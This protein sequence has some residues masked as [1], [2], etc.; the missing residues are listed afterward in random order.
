MTV[1]SGPRNFAGA[2]LTGGFRD[3]QFQKYVGYIWNRG[4]FY[5]HGF[6]A[7]DVPTDSRDVTMLYND[8]GVGY[9]L[10]QSPN[11]GAFLSAIAPTFETHV[12]VPLNHRGALRFN[13]PAGTADVVDLT[14]GI[15]AFLGKRSVLTFA[16]VNPVTGPRPFNSEWSI[17][18]NFNFGN[19]RV[20]RPSPPV[21]GL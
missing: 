17:L 13:D 6:E 8:F 10:Y 21:V 12:N 20:R 5:A 3:V 18:Y 1:P 14:F 15:N 2:P 4:R 9:Y 19:P 16:Y 7:I 11:P